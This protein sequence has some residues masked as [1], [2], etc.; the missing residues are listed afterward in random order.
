MWLLDKTLPWQKGYKVKFTFVEE[1]KKKDYIDS[2]WEGQTP[3]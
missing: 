1:G 2:C 3:L